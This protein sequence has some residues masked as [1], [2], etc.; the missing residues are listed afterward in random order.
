MFSS[1]WFVSFQ[2]VAHRQIGYNHAVDAN[3]L[4]FDTEI[5]KTKLH[6]RIQVAHHHQWDFNFRANVGQLL[7]KFSDAHAVF[8]RFSTALLY[9]RPIGHGVGKWNANFYHVHT[10]SLQCFDGGYRVVQFWKSGGDVNGEY[11]FVFCLKKIINSVHS[12]R[13][14]CFLQVCLVR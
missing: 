14:P 9:H 8:E 3:A 5:F 10:V 11:V 12:F 13:S 1:Y 6:N 7:E 4:T 2:I